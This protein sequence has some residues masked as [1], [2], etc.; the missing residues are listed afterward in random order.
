MENWRCRIVGH[1]FVANVC[2]RCGI[3]KD[4]F[5]QRSLDRRA[6][7]QGELISRAWSRK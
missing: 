5:L 2:K 4:E 1:R 3:T 6:Q 7:E